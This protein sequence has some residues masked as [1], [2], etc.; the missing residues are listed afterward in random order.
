[1]ITLPRRSFDWPASEDDRAAPSRSTARDDR[2][3]DEALER[4]L[5][6]PQP[7]EA[8]DDQRELVEFDARKLERI[9][10][11]GTRRGATPAAIAGTQQQDRQ[12][13]RA[14][15]GQAAQFGGGSDGEQRVARLKRSLEPTTWSSRVAHERL[16]V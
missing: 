2:A 5:A 9:A 1:M 16:F 8:R 12:S 4:A 13:E 3:A 15:E 6:T 7:I 14:V 10:S 11:R